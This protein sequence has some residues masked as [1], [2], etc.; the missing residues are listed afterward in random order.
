MLTYQECLEL[1]DLSLDEID[2]IARHEHVPEIIAAEMGNYLMQN[3][4]GVPCIKRYILDDI[5]AAER[6]GN[7]KRALHLKLVLQHFI[8][9]HPEHRADAI[10]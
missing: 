7:R 4:D 8:E 6:H 2:A 10:G 5:E 1:C 3:P 9:T